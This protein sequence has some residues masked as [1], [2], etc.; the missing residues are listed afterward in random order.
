MTHENPHRVGHDAAGAVAQ[1][2]QHQHTTPPTSIQSHGT[3]LDWALRYASRGLHD[4]V[5]QKIAP[6]FRIGIIAPGFF[7]VRE[8]QL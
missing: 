7:V 5:D 4:V 6:G 8:Q 1:F 2:E 3:L